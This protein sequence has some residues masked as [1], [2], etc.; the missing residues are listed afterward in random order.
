MRQWLRR[1]RRPSDREF[2]AEVESHLAH[3]TDER[4]EAGL[5]PEEARYAALRGFGNVTRHIERFREASPWFWLETLWQDVRYGWRSLSRS[6][7]LFGAAVVSL[8]LAIGGTTAMVSVLHATVID[9]LPFPHGGRLA[10]LVQYDCHRA[11]DTAR[12]RQ[13]PGVHRIHETRRRL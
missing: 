2:A 4:V 5:P 9:P 10:A 11:G 6:P 7:A 3:E 12:L 13:G 1:F 8:A